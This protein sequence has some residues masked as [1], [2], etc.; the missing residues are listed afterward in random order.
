MSRCS[1]HG[2]NTFALLS[3]CVQLTMRGICCAQ[4]NNCPSARSQKKWW[5]Q[6][7]MHM[8]FG[9]SLALGCLL[10]SICAY[11]TVGFGWRRQSSLMMRKSIEFATATLATPDL[12]IASASD[13]SQSWFKATQLNSRPVLST[14]LQSKMHLSTMDMNRYLT[15][16]VSFLQPNELTTLATEL[17]DLLVAKSELSITVDI[18]TITAVLYA[19][20]QHKMYSTV[21][22]I[23]AVVNQTLI[24]EQ[25]HDLQPDAHYFSLVL[26]AAVHTKP[27]KDCMDMLQ[28]VATLISPH[29]LEPVVH[30][31]MTTLLYTSYHR[32][33]A[34][35]KAFELFAFAVQHGVVPSPRLCDAMCI[36]LCK[37]GSV[38]D[39]SE[40][41]AC[42][43]TH[44]ISLTI[45]SFNTLLHRLAVQGKVSQCEGM[46]DL[47][48]SL[49]ILPSPYT[50]EM[51]LK[52]CSVSG[53]VV[54]AEQIC[55]EMVSS[56]F[57]LTSEATV[58]LMQVLLLLVAEYRR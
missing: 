55:E 53:D 34:P 10:C 49:H 33:R 46:R 51:M 29:T 22:H 48:R 18:K 43:R 31:T 42:M 56:G 15:K 11:R 40:G 8:S 5:F 6:G 44:N 9:V 23:H 26:R 45:H 50:F 16:R 39:V 35:Q 52:A 7:K 27:W 12:T 28:H 24:T 38:A 41:L 47:M 20:I 21:L 36:V 14:L 30:S 3:A 19:S 57:A 25:Q 58:L 32:E 4:N 54:K 1:Q 13:K 37:H 2:T 17:S